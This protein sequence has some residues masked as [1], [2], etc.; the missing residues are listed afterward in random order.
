MM[1][2]LLTGSIAFDYLMSFP[3]L[4]RDHILPENIDQVSLSFLVDDLVHRSGGIAANIAYTM[5]QLGVRPTV[6]ATV[7]K[8][9]APQRAALG[10]L[11]IDTSEIRVVEGVATASFFATTDQS[12]AQIASFFTGAMAYAKQQSLLELQ[13]KPELVVISPNDPEAMVKFC[14]EALQARIAYF[15][16]PSQQIVRLAGPDLRRGIEGARAIFTNE[17]ESAL[18]YDKTGLDRAALLE[19]VAFQ[20]TTL[21]EQGA[22]IY[23]PTAEIHIPAIPPGKMVDPTGVGDA[24]RAGFLVGY[25]HGFTLELCGQIGALAATYCLESDGPQG[26]KISP[27]AFIERFRQHFDDRGVLDQLT[28]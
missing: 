26:H 6:M 20:V 27:A 17:Y 25:A 19:L 7:G 9:Y 11:G 16:D 5:A 10:A 3:G 2:I 13:S 15:Y 1:K 22:A 24:F 28:P 18:I 4:F 21:G 14:Q 12:N 8:D 23:T